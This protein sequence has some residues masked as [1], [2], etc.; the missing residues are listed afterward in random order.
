MGHILKLT[1]AMML[2]CAGLCACNSAGCIDGHGTI[3]LAGFYGSEGRAVSIDSIAV[4]GIGA[5]GD[6]LLVSPKTA[7]SQTY[8][9]LRAAQPATAFCFAYHSKR[10]DDPALN[11][12]LRIDYSATP[13]F[14]SDECGVGYEYR[15]KRAECTH[16]LID[17]VIV[18][19]S[20]VISSTTESVRIYFRTAGEGDEE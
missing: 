2:A 14:I 20:A 17:S 5:T 9:P 12:T 19:D 3:P 7:A 4:W 15:I 11:D 8:L 18:V 1:L 16:H 10:L 6:S 13:M